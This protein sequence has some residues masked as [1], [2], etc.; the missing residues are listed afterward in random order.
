MTRPPDDGF[1]D[2]A[3]RWARG[4]RLEH[5]LERAELA[6]GDFVRN[7][8]QLIDLL[9]QLAVV[10]PRAATAAAA[11]LAADRLQRG[12]VAA[13]GALTSVGETLAEKGAEAASEEGVEPAPGSPGP[14][15]GGS[16]TW[17]GGRS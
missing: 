10:S 9:R 16:A 4:Q 14:G 5:V 11:R 2:A 17:D 13:S 1:C 15:G 8:K 3:R 7:T 12:V 6:P